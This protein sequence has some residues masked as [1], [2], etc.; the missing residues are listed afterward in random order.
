M[1]LH[2]FGGKRTFV[3]VALASCAWW[4]LV[5]SSLPRTIKGAVSGRIDELL[6]VLMNTLEEESTHRPLPAPCRTCE[7]Q[8]FSPPCY[9]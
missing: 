4:T 7:P 8:K 1:G 3:Q 5:Y 6:L 2:R 9:S